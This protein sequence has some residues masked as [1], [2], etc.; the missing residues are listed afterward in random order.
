MLEKRQA[1]QAPARRGIHPFALLRQMT[2]ELDR[3][4]FDD[5]PSMSWPVFR[6]AALAEAA[7]CPKI[8][9]FQKD[10][11]FIMRVDLPGVKKEDLALEVKYGY[12]T[13]AG[14]RKNEIKEEREDFYRTEREYG[15][16]YRA[17]P[18]PEGVNVDDIRAVFDN[19]V[20]EVS[21]PLPVRAEAKPKM[22]T[23]EEPAGKEMA[24]V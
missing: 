2:S 15:R 20:L 14:E 12:L 1:A 18:L 21:V 19:G 6:A 8:D 4:L 23:I 11:R 17:V 10:N 5:W 24:A 7:W 16:F 13:I 9:M 22:V 3:V